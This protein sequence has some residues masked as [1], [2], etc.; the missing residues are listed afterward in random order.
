MK[1]RLFSLI[2]L[3][4]FVCYGQNPKQLDSLNHLIKESKENNSWKTSIALLYNKG[5]L[6]NS[7]KNYEEAQQQFLKVDSISK[8]YN[9]SD[10]N[11]VL[12]TVERAEISKSTFSQDG[13]ETAN[14][15]LIQ[16]L[17]DAKKLNNEALI[18]KVYK[19]LAYIKFLMNETD[20]SRL[21]LDLAMPYYLKK[22]DTRS[23]SRLHAVYSFYF[24]KVD[25][26]KKAEDIRITSVDYL[27]KHNDSIELA[28]AISSLG[29]FYS[30]RLHQYRKALPYLNE[31]KVIYEKT[32]DTLIRPY[33]IFN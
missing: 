27:R 13:V 31:A 18:Y 8:R 33:L 15:L 26:I 10:E 5:K 24:I 19:D 11:T 1:H 23:V 16:A 6:Y 4:S 25:S 22:D 2:I 29:D 20:A 21:Y 3:V 30:Y 14:T 9:H 12:A 32:H 28:K 17:D 7:E